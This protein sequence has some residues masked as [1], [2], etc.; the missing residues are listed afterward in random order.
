MCKSK[1][2]DHSIISF[3]NLNIILAMILMIIEEVYIKVTD[4]TIL[5]VKRKKNEIV[6]ESSNLRSPT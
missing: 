3:S 4:L 6:I 5:E 1:Y 2:I